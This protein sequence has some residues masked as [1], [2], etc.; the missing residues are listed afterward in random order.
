MNTFSDLDSLL[1]DE[2]FLAH[3]G[4]PRHSGRYPWGSGENPYQH[5]QDFLSR[6]EALKKT[7]WEE[8]PENIKNEFGLTTGQYRTP[9]LDGLKGFDP[10]LEYGGE[11]K[12]DSNGEK[13]YYRDGHE[14][15]VMK[16]TQTEMG[17]ISN[18][19]TDM[20]LAGADEKELAR[21][22]RHSM[23]VI[24]AEKHKLDYK[25]SEKDNNIAQLR[26]DYQAKYDENGNLVRSGGA[27]TILSRAKG[28]TSVP[29]T[30]GTPKINLKDKSWYD[31]S[32][33]EGSLI[34]KTADDLYYP[35]RTIDKKTGTVTIKTADGDTIKYNTTDKASIDRYTPVKRK[36]NTTGEVYY[37][38]RTG[39]IR[40]EM[41]M[42]TKKSTKMAETDD[43]YTLV[44]EA[45]HP[46]ELLYAQYANDMKGLAN[47]ARIEMSYTGKIATSK[48][49]KSKYKDEIDSLDAK[50]NDALKNTVKER[51][52]QRMANVE[53]NEKKQ[54]NPDMKT[55]DLKKISQQ[56]LTKYRQQVG[57][58]ARRDRAIEITDREWE[59]IQS[60]AISENKLKQILNNANP[61]VLR[62]RSMP[63][64]KR[65][66][67]QVQINRIK[68]YAA[69]DYTLQE[70]ADKMNLSVS[71]VSKYLKGG[72]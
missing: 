15:K 18:L 65:S 64:E 28:E 29:A 53:I 36:D 23:V 17:K 27:S 52:A 6:V 56:A 12:I 38:D 45:R 66:I 24:D 16:N 19:I 48:E 69:S 61:D 2:N 33:P 7:G 22:V 58:V 39:K 1:L 10:K 21:A 70:I 32:R 5:G 72:N 13:H 55:S 71:A 46:M 60:G 8:T 35:N 40:Y 57:S 3:Y 67:S 4:T 41:K 62:E 31:P 42:R 63:K 54:S 43:A 34:Y 68:A 49:A 25:A 37:T 14:Y 26:K 59:A 9:E 51:T 30:Q 11:V 47:K 44:S 50:L 20:T